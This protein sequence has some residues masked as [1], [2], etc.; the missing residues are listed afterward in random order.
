MKAYQLITSDHA[1]VG[2][3]SHNDFIPVD[4][5]SKEQIFER[6]KECNKGK[7]RLTITE[8]KDVVFYFQN[9]PKGMP[10]FLLFLATHKLEM[11]IINLR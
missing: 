8:V 3:A 4:V 2:G 11:N 1:I 10:K 9:T 7:H 5:L 6:L